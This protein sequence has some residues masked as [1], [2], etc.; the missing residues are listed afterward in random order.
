M[1]NTTSNVEGVGVAQEPNNGNSLRAQ[2]LR[3]VLQKVLSSA[4]GKISEKAIQRVYQDIMTM[5]TKKC[6]TDKENINDSPPLTSE[7]LTNLIKNQ[8]IPKFI[9]TT[10]Q[11]F[12]VLCQE[13]DIDNKLAVL[14]SIM[15]EYEQMVGKKNRNIK[16]QNLSQNKLLT[17]ADDSNTEM[18]TSNDKIDQNDNMQVQFTTQNNDIE[19]TESK[20]SP[21]DLLMAARMKIKEEEKERLLQLLQLEEEEC[22]EKEQELSDLTLRLHNAVQSV[23]S[24]QQEV[25]RAALI[26]NM[27]N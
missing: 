20:Y 5:S 24:Y 17:T 11:E 19:E 23:A 21:L 12:E 26:A 3:Q 6:S 10:E 14:E 18:V 7:Y 16:N 8:L 1:M 15:E 25:E 9:S 13:K 22:T 2:R 4:T 27:K